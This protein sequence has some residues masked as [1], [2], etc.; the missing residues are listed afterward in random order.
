M[1]YKKV[2]QVDLYKKTSGGGCLLLIVIIII[3]YVLSHTK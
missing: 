1:G 2:G 3:L